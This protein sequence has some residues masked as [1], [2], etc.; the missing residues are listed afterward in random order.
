MRKLQEATKR[1]DCVEFKLGQQT[2]NMMREK[3]ILDLTKFELSR[4][5]EDGPDD[6]ASSSAPPLAI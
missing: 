4:C 5:I 3:D 2:D 1:L 6:S